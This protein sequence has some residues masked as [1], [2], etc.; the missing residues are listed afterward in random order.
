MSSFL[1]LSGVAAASVT[2]AALAPSAIA[3]DAASTWT[4]QDV[5]ASQPEPLGDREGHSLF[6]GDYSCRI[7]G[8]PLSGGVVTG[9]N[10]W[11]HDG[12]K[13]TRLASQGVIR[14]PGAVVAFA[15]GM[16]S[17]VFTMT[18]GKVTG[19]TASGTGKNVLAAGAWA[20]L[21]GKAN[22]WTAKPTGPGQFLVELK[23]E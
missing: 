23:F 20:P 3:Q 11:E 8:G 15:G 21:A 18:D 7:D 4:C 14:K 10:I 19:W 5:G 1:H 6:V 9:S 22:T 16:G 2:F 13:S 17:I 12:P